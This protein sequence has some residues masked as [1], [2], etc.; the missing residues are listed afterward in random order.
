MDAPFAAR[1]AAARDLADI[2]EL[3]KEAVRVSLGLERGGLML[4]LADLGNHPRGFL[5]AFYPA[6]SNAIVMNRVPLLRIQATQPD[7]YRPYVFMVLLHEY[8]HALG[9]LDEEEVRV[10][11]YRV[12][13]R[14]LGEEDPATQMALNPLRYFPYL[15]FPDTAWKPEVLHLE[16]VPGFDRSSVSYIH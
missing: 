14:M 4:A 6:D 12:C 15:V 13:R 7:L 5:G 9:Y 10:R 16:W 1:L 2:F 3:A 8:L 11:T